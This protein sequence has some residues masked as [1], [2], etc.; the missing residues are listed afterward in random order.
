M[1]PTP[2]PARA[3]QMQGMYIAGADAGMPYPYPYPL[4]APYPK[5]IRLILW[6]PEC[7]LVPGQIIG[8]DPRAADMTV[9]YY[10]MGQQ[11]PTLLCPTGILYVTFIIELE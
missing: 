1:A 8:W 11:G 4:P 3:V 7:R 2:T 6:A 5:Q 10:S 9:P